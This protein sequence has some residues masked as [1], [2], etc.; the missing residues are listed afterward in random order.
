LVNL[1]HV[2]RLHQRG[3]PYYTATR[4]RSVD[5][6]ADDH[7]HHHSNVHGG[8]NTGAASDASANPGSNARADG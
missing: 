4:R 2:L 1:R 8:T 5:R 6:T 3:D 7:N